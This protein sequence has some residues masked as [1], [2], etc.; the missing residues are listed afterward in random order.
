[1][2]KEPTNYNQELL[3]VC[4]NTLGTLVKATGAQYDARLVVVGGL[5]PRLLMDETTLDPA[6]SGESHAG[7]SDVD[8]CIELDV[9]SG[10]EDFYQQL[11]TCLT[12]YSFERAQ[13]G[14]IRS[15]WSWVRNIGHVRMVVDL[16]CNADEVGIAQPGRLTKDTSSGQYDEIGALRL[17]GAHLALLDP[18]IKQIEVELL[19]GGGRSKVRVRVASLLAFLVLKSFALEG[20]IEPKDAYDIVWVLA[21]WNHGPRA[22][23]QHAKACRGA[24]HP[25]VVEAFRLLGEEFESP[26]TSGC[27]NYAD[28][29]MKIAAQSS[30]NSRAKHQRDAY[31]TIKQFLEGWQESAL[32]TASVP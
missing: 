31:N 1:M 28:F 25:D 17:R 12:K 8:L 15:R 32:S 24:D 7:T 10:D 11:E 22:A 30:D 4:L 13:N 16:L 27:V 9:K 14:K 2:S 23:A 3:Q 19:D 21:R 18:V 6:F 26:D 29:T 20:R 5:V